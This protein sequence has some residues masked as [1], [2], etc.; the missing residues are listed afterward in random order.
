MHIVGF[1]LGLGLFGLGS[2]IARLCRAFFI[3]ATVITVQKDDNLM[4]ARLCRAFFMHIVG[5]V[6]G[7]GL[8]G[9]GSVIARLC[10]AFFMHI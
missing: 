4:I 3:H 2:V 7:L 5:F 10:R 9:L 6:L 1:V 8:F